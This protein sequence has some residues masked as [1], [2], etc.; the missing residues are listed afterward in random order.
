MSIEGSFDYCDGLPL[1]AETEPIV[2]A[3]VAG[4]KVLEELC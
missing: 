2:L 3:G 4:A 1:R